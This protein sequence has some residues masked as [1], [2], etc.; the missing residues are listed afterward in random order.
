MSYDTPIEPEQLSMLTKVLSDYCTE[1]GIPESHPARDHFARRLMSLFQRG[2]A[3][4]ADLKAKMNDGYEEWLGEIG[5]TGPFH[6]PKL[7]AEDR[8]VGDNIL[9]GSDLRGRPA[10]RNSN[11]G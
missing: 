2:V 5:A 9:P 6:P 1:A 8:L 3:D 10:A 11:R 4:A 7:S